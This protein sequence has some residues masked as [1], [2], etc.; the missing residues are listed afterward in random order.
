MFGN[1]T[2]V[3]VTVTL[4]TLVSA[5]AD[6]AEPPSTSALEGRRRDALLVD[7]ALSRG[8]RDAHDLALDADVSGPPASETSFGSDPL[9]AIDGDESTAWRGRPGAGEW[10]WALPFH[11]VVHLALVRAS[12][13]DGPM[14]GVPSAYRWETQ[15]PVD[16]R[17]EPWALWSLVPG[18]QRDDR[19]DNVFLHGDKDIHAQR[20]ALFT[21]VDACGL[22]LVVT[23]MD[24]GGPVLREVKLVEGAPSLSRGARVEAPSPSPVLA[25]SS[26]EGVVDGTYEGA[27]AG[28]AGAGEWTVTVRLPAPQVVDRTRLVLGEDAVTSAQRGTTG[29]VFSGGYL[30]TRYAIETSPDDSPAHLVPLS[31]ADPP[32]DGDALLPV[33]R[34]LIKHSPRVVKT[35]RLTIHA[36]TGR[37]GERESAT[38]AP[39]VREIGLY[40]AS[41]ARPVVAEPTF[42]SV[43]A[44]PSGLTALGK[45]GEAYADGVFARDAYHR[46]RRVLVGFDADTR[47]PA[48]ASRRR[49]RGT[50]RF[51]EAIEGDDP[52]L[53]RAL[54]EASSPRPIVLLSGALDWEFGDRTAPWPGKAAHWTW[55]VTSDAASAG[56][57]MGRLGPA[58]RDRV[59]AFVGFC[60]GAQ[61][62]ALLAAD[63]PRDAIVMRN[64]NTPIRGLLAVEDPYERAWWSDAPALD[65]ARPTIELDPLDALF[66]TGEPGPRRRETRELPSLHGDTIRASAFERWLSPFQVVAT[67]R[68]CRRW[69]ADGLEPTT[70][71]GDAR[72]LIVPQAFR[73]SDPLTRPIVGFQFHPEQR[74]LQRLAEGSP[75]DARAD[76]LAAFSNAIALALDAYVRLELPLD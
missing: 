46:L 45:G 73:T 69:V 21:D 52:S 72:C 66:A 15:A 62:L 76:A 67:S 70:R 9:E 12:F 55:D 57:G 32:H 16:G 27:W 28:T 6:A 47:W 24:R 2:S 65:R 71:D 23:A 5:L 68:F 11:R 36:A 44:N 10:I 25:E 3:V 75:P 58:V 51:L 4:S 74:D 19:D 7:R 42:L 53:G 30:P 14:I 64:A 35:L 26:A 13:G 40:A 33:R 38:A 37:W 54:L 34:R 29:R 31:E 59:A 20:Q 41:D 1:R 48:D 61:I 63:A 50:G 56:R 17:C 18:G 8:P 22:R 39:V 60:G 49:D 43:D